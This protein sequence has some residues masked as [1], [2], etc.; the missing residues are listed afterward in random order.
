MDLEI[1]PQ[2][3]ARMQE[4]KEDFFLLDVREPREYETARIEGSALIPMS[5]VPQRVDELPS[6]K[7]IVV[8]CHHG[9]RSMQVVMWLRRQGIQAC[10]LNGGIDRWS[11]EVDPRVPRY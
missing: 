7:A 4:A 2:E 11:V 5:Q 9:G 10:N 6:D 3:L 8:H 1:E